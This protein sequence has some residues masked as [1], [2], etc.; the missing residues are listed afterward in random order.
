M[1]GIR[2]SRRSF[3][4][5]LAALAIFAS[6]TAQAAAIIESDK[7][8][9]FLDPAGEV[10]NTPAESFLSNEKH[11]FLFKWLSDKQEET[12]YPG[13]GNSPKLLFMGFSVEEANVR[14]KD[15]KLNSIYLSLF[16]RGDAGGLDSEAFNKLIGDI[17]GKISEWSSDKG[18][19]LKRSNL[20]AGSTNTLAKVWIKEP[21]ALTLKWS[22][23]GKS[24][25]DFKAEYVQL[26]I[27][28]FDVK[29]DPRKQTSLGISR[30]DMASAKSLPE[31]IKRETNKDVF[32]DGIPMVDQGNKPYCV[33]AAASR[34]FRYYCMEVSQ[35]D[36]AQIADS[37]AEKG[38][39]IKS[40]VDAIKRVS[41]RY[42][43]KLREYYQ[44]DYEKMISKYNTLAKKQKKQPIAIHERMT[45]DE[46]FSSMSDDV[47]R[48]MRVEVEKNDMKGFLKD[49]KDSIDKGVPPLWIVM[50]GLVKEDKLTPQTRG[51]HMRLIIGYNE[52][53][54]M[55][56]YSDSW[57]AD[58]E[59]KKMSY[60]DAWVLT[61]G[62]ISMDPLK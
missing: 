10:F 17:D 18:T 30:K 56:I 60:D 54:R 49:V 21:Y 22:S 58:H 26:E 28:K 32:I 37:D 16:N 15:G 40:M 31:N 4:P 24:R 33:D 42:G 47:F 19:P 23:S 57:G 20:I 43:V 11:K 29:N 39:S 53:D 7:F 44:I 8:E 6:A 36:I 59:F 55:I 5:C 62:L 46:V 52:K 34:V 9:A 41:S 51:G 61:Q 38:T 12:H 14:F 1:N 13:W 25:K 27:E 50:L 2:L 45:L 48:K 35:H 3:M